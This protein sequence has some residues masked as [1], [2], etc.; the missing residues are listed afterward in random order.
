MKDDITGSIWGHLDGLALQGPEAGSRLELIPLM[1]TT[2]SRWRELHPNT[3]VMSDDTQWHDVYMETAIGRTGLS[4]I[5]VASIA[6]WDSRL[7][8]AALVLGVE[9]NGRFTAYPLELLDKAESV[10][11]AEAGGLPYVVLYDEL[12]RTGLA[13]S[14]TLD[15]Q[16]LEFETSDGGLFT[17]KATG[18]TWNVSGQALEGPM[19]GAQLEYLPSFV[20]EWYGWVAAHPKP[21]FTT[22]SRHLNLSVPAGLLPTGPNW[23]TTIYR[24]FTSSYP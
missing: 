18:S 21:R 12:G 8:E 16:V 1:L 22:T 15:G 14:R 10:I 23:T 24:S 9:A 19:T 17:D 3:L 20:T 5:F 11:N 2:W 7:P 4:P 13:F 6:N